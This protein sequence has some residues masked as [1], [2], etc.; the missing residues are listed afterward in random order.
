MPIGV[1]YTIFFRRRHMD[2]ASTIKWMTKAI[3]KAKRSAK[4]CASGCLPDIAPGIEVE[5]LGTIKLPL[6]PKTAKQL[7][8]QCKIAPYGKGTKTLID[9]KVRNTFELDPKKFQLTGGDWDAAIAA[10]T[11]QVAGQL[12][13]P[14]DRVEAKPYKLLVYQRGGFFLPHRDSEKLNRMVASMIVVLP[15]PFDGGALVVRHE[16]AK[17]TFP[18]EE[19][20]RGKSPCYVAFY[21]DCEHEVQRVTGGYRLCLAYNLLLRGGKWIKSSSATVR[22]AEP[23][24]VLAESIG[25]WV[26]AQQAEPLVF[27]LEHHYTQRGLSLDLLKGA[28]REIADL[29]VA[30]AAKAD[31]FVHLAQVTRHLLQFA[32]DGS[33]GRSY[34]RYRPARSRGYEIG[35]T[36][37]DDLSGTQWT[38]ARGKKQPFGEI[39]FDR[40]AIVS[41][42]PIDDWQPTSEE[43]EGYTGNAGN[44]LDRWYHRS[45]IVVWHRDHHFDVV[46]RCGT[47][48]SIELFCSMVSKLPRTPKKRMEQARDDCIRF[49][50]AI[51]A[52]WPRRIARSGYATAEPSPL[53]DA[54][55]K[56]LLALGDQKTIAMWLSKLAGH[57]ETLRL[58][59]FVQATCR[60]FG[61]N[62]L[63]AE[64]KRL[65][66]LPEKPTGYQ[67]VL[68]RNV[69][70]LFALCCDKSIVAGSAE[71][72]TEL[73]A[74]AVER[75]CESPPPR[76]YYYRAG[77]SV[78]VKSLPKLLKALL[79]IDAA[80]DL[81]RII[82]FV[83][84]SPDEFSLEA[85]Q[86]PSLNALIP[87]SQ[88][89]DGSAHPQLAGW[90]TAVRQELESATAAR[91]APPAD[92]A[93]P[94]EVQCS[95]RYCAAL[96]AFLADPANERTRI[97]AREDARQHVISM[98]RKHE[99]DV[100][101]ALERKGSPYSLVLT[102]TIGSHERALKRFE[103]DRKLL[104][105]L[106]S[107]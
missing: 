51:V 71:L 45:A 66:S 14:P 107:W 17:Q 21:A 101:H 11:Q 28:D 38:D 106:P 68:L 27:A 62:T 96:N 83:R 73:C 1:E 61:A 32:D 97:A 53:P 15:S 40:S 52:N 69:E 67:E 70:W 104:K 7:I 77:T 54:F 92:W 46:A 13:L 103:A 64:L 105:S 93:R 8:A 5:D 65:I 100:K 78:S 85:A 9:K 88:K 49:A 95:C 42:V 39:A 90:L 41:S 18:L 55:A 25:T 12:G 29:L 30:A 33:F 16:S 72:L 58:D 43:F 31:C 87:W 44:T 98:I 56:Q 23:T 60:E 10:A 74:I 82:D 50:R 20:A 80:R 57:D 2:D 47:E 86:V 6:K 84:S 34:S 24:E 102:K 89:R 75:F 19:A 81:A 76:P 48:P 3:D 36:Y 4:F 59:R 63:A 37:E 99:C 22:S 35:E 94:A 91:P 79:A 26:A